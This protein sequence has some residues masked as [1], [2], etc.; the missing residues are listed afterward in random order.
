MSSEREFAD[1]GWDLGTR[2]AGGSLLQPEP[3]PLG[4][5]DPR[6]LQDDMGEEY[7]SE[8]QSQNVRSSIILFVGMRRLISGSRRVHFA[9]SCPEAYHRCCGGGTVDAEFI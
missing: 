3:L 9:C 4:S 5:L 1:E 8:R 7:T 6:R 2:V